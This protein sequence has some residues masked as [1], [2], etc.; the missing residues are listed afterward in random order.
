[1]YV[2]GNDNKSSFSLKNATIALLIGGAALLGSFMMNSTQT[3]TVEE[4][5]LDETLT[6]FE[7]DQTEI[8]EVLDDE[9]TEAVGV[10]E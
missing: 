2:K 1:V 7:Q 8:I 9:L 10:T 5:S 6:T 4:I 3:Q